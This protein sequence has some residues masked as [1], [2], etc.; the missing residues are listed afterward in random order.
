[1]G[2]L[3]GSKPEVPEYVL[4][5]YR[6]LNDLISKGINLYDSTD[7]NKLDA[8][9]VKTYGDSAM[10]QA[11]SFLQNYDAKATAGGSPIYKSDTAKDR[12]RVQI[13]ADSALPVAQFQAG[14]IASQPGRRASL[15]PNPGNA[16]YGFNPAMYL[17][18]QAQGNADSQLQGLMAAAQLL[19]KIKWGKGSR[20]TGQNDR[21][22]MV[23]RNNDA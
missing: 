2:S 18:Q 23:I 6:L 13:S 7:F 1:L 17:D 20:P 16:S 8:E 3:F 21:Y 10:K 15:L 19:G 14:L 12:A 5:Q 9:A 4:Q 22:G 11:M